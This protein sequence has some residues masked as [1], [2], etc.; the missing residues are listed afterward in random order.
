MSIRSAVTRRVAV[1]GALT[2][3]AAVAVTGLAVLPASANHTGTFIPKSDLPSGSAY[4]PWTAQAPKAGLPKPMYTCIQGILPKSRSSHQVFTADLTAEV[5]EI[6]TRTS[7]KASA[8][9]L[10][11]SLRKAVTSCEDALDDVT[12]IK[13]YGSYSTE[14]G[15][16]IDGVFTAPPNSEYNFQLFGIGRDGKNVVVTTFSDMGRKGEAPVSKFTTTA[17]AALKKAF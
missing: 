14:E 8:K 9:T 1:T 7:S 3:S 16:T 6:I 11:K 15:L 5:R 17:K 10:V 13:R 4:T 2:V 12:D